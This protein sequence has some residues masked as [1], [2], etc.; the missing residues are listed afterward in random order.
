[1]ALRI[2]LCGYFGDLHLNYPSASRLRC[3]VF[4]DDLNLDFRFV[5]ITKPTIV[6]VKFHNRN[7]DANVSKYVVCFSFLLT[8]N[9]ATSLFISHCF[10]QF[11][12]LSL[13]CLSCP[14][15]VSFLLVP[16]VDDLPGSCAFK[17][18][19]KITLLGK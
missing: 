5:Q 11:P 12:F 7:F 6:T 10:P 4:F 17:L 13:L 18:S 14:C 8:R 19:G 15:H 9:I 16:E 3:T 1:M 2:L